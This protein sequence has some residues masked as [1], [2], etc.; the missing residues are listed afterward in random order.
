MLNHLQYPTALSAHVRAHRRD[1]W[2]LVHNHDVTADLVRT[3]PN[4]VERVL[5]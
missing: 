1:S 4:T 2:P 3:L 5:S